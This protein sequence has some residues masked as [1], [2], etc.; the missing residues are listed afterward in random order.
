MTHE[1]YYIYFTSIFVFPHRL[2]ISDIIR[3]IPD[4]SSI[5][6]MAFPVDSPVYPSSTLARLLLYKMP[7]VNALET[8]YDCLLHLLR[9][10]LIVR[11][12]SKK[13]TNLSIK[14]PGEVPDLPII[15]DVLRTFSPNLRWLSVSIRGDLPA[16][17]F[18]LILLLIFGELCP[19]LYHFN[20]FLYYR[21]S[22]QPP[23]FDEQFKKN[24]K[25][26]IC[27]QVEKNQ[28]RLSTLEYHIRDYELSISF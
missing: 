18:D 8:S 21:T 2:I 15:T 12:L 19:K 25:N 23:I 24:L 26:G 22:Q 10:P 6:T 27:A 17:T 11:I 5:K 1:Y 3:S 7:K 20:F 13:I 14:F 4:L 9:F 16:M 28:A